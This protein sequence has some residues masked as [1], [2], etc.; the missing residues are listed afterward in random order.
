MTQADSDIFNHA[1][2]EPVADDEDEVQP[3]RSGAQRTATLIRLVLVGALTVIAAVVVISVR[4]GPVAPGDNSVAAGLARDMI[5]HHAQAVDMATIIQ[6]RTKDPA[7]RT[8]A[9]D[10]ALTQTN[11]M[12]QMQGWLNDWNLS[13]GRSG[14]QMA[15][16]NRDGG[17]H[18][19]GGSTMDPSLMRLRPDGLMPGMAT[20][21]QVNQLRTLPSAEADKLFLQLMIAH[22]RGGVAMA[23]TALAETTER[24]VVRLCRTIVTDQQLEIVQKT[25]ML[26]ERA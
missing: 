23:Q 5:D 12:G 16:M 9:T 22:H 15:W 3:G 26:Q 19:G 4:S 24:V 10:I 7:I 11:Q 2:D 6:A 8:L 18:M 1:D 25:Q 13:L 14:P 20:Q 21:A 17:M